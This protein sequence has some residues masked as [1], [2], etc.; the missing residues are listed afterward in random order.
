[1]DRQ[2]FTLILVR[3]RVGGKVVRQI[4]VE[5]AES[6]EEAQE[7]PTFCEICGN[8]DREDRM[9]L[10]DGCDL[11]YHME[12]LNPPLTHVPID[13]WYCSDCDHNNTNIAEEVKSLLH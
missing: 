5:R 4:R 6:K 11:G 8:S 7:D 12:C 2:E 9:L 13:N 10:C 3:R 1:M